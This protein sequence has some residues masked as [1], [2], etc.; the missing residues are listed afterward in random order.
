MKDYQ[1]EKSCTIGFSIKAELT[2]EGVRICANGD[3]FHEQIMVMPWFDIMQ[4][5]E[6]EELSKLDETP[7]HENA[8]RTTDAPGQSQAPR[9]PDD[10]SPTG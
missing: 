1:M 4:Y 10:R 2:E 6:E 8:E 5:L 3:A 9:S 7:T